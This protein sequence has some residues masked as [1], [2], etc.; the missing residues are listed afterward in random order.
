M[1]LRVIA[2]LDVKPPYVVKPVHFEGLR[3]I[4][5]PS[6]LSIKYYD[7]GADEILYI[8]IVA[9]LYNRDIIHNEIEKASNNI[10]IPFAAGGGVKSISDFSSILRHGA[11]K[12][13]INTHALQKNPDLIS[14]CSDTFGSQAV[15]VHIQAKRWNN[16][17]ECYSDC[18]RIQSGKD[19]I[20]W[21]SE[22]EN[23]GAG[24]ILI[25]CID[26]DG[27]QKGYDIN[28]ISKITKKIHIPVIA[29]S[30]AGSLAHI[31][32]LVEESNPDAI[33]VASF[34]HYNKG[35]IGDIKRYLLDKNIEVS[36]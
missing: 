20:D 12:V 8:D 24:E 1:T 32:E 15:V 25:S 7:Q 21:A 26:T 28:L 9:S 29:G 34:L 33:A 17:W 10:F 11:D 6:D 3:K 22:A 27:R 13:V 30:G 35:T 31:G 36:L 18:G 14:K 2:R 19:V 23:L 16:W 5:T 4:G